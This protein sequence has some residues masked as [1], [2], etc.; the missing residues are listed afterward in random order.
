MLGRHEYVVLRGKGVFKDV[1]NLRIWRWAENPGL[2]CCAQQNHKVLS[3]RKAG[4][5][6]SEKCDDGNRD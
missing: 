4:V 5:S 2:S 1:V 6:G 3:K